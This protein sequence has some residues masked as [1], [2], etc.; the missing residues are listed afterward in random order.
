MRTACRVHGL[1]IRHSTQLA[2]GRKAGGEK[3]DWLREGRLERAERR[4][5][6]SS[7]LFI[8]RVAKTP[9]RELTFFLRKFQEGCAVEDILVLSAEAGEYPLAEELQRISWE[10]EKEHGRKVHLNDALDLCQNYYTPTAVGISYATFR[11][12]WYK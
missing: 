7:V 10:A 1:G 6:C 8:R 3:E 2:E 5:A 11:V 4:S 12:S 9:E